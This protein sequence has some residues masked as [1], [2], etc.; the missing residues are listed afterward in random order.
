[1]QNVSENAM[2]HFLFCMWARSPQNRVLFYDVTIMPNAVERNLAFG[3][4]RFE[5]V[6]CGWHSYLFNTCF[7]TLARFPYF[8]TFASGGGGGVG[9]TPL[10]IGP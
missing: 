3:V 2:V 8:S 7:F 10:A 4:Y 5:I 6:Y 9:P 1:M